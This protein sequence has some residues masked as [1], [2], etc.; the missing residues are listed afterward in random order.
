MRIIF[1]NQKSLFPEYIKAG[2]SYKVPF[3]GIKTGIAP[4]IN[5]GAS[6]LTM[7]CFVLFQYKK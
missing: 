5:F 6:L 3:L 4:I 7:E 1:I 2:F